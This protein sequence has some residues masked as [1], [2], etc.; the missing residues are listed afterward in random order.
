M[1]APP[2]S[3]SSPLKKAFASGRGLFLE[4]YSSPHTHPGGSIWRTTVQKMR[5]LVNFVARR[6]ALGSGR[7]DA[8]R[9]LNNLKGSA[10]HQE[11]LVIG[12]GPSSERLN[13]REAKKRQARGELVVVATNYY[14]NSQAAD[15]L[16]PDYL[17]WADRAF[18]PKNPK[19][20]AAWK[21]VKQWDGVTLVV[22]WTW[23]QAIRA[24]EMQNRMVYFDNDSL[25][26]WTNNISPA[27]PRGYQGGTGVK[28]LAFALHLEPKVVFLVGVDLSYYKNFAVDEENR[29]IRRPSHVTGTDSG[30]QDISQ[31]SVA[32]LA[33]ALYSTANQFLALHKF[34]SGRSIVNLDAGSL[35]DAFPK[36]STHPLMRKAVKRRA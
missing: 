16:T 35:V 33:D 1:N 3:R 32:G 29:V 24:G 15:S 23:R 8:L 30:V 36:V 4:R 18:D 28:A 14:F 10:Q 6:I 13:V 27:R 7:S 31:H 5:V 21:T 17:V 25:E 12:S 11:I 9:S 26:G 19:S 34:F 2:D 20:A 22:P